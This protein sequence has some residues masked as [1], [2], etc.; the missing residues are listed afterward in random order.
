MGP[1]LP[2]A[3]PVAAPPLLP[4]L[5]LAPPLPPPPL[6]PEPP[7]AGAPELPLPVGVPIPPEPAGGV[8]PALPPADGVPPLP[9]PVADVPPV[10]GPPSGDPPRDGAGIDEH[11]RNQQAA[12][13]QHQKVNRRERISFGTSDVPYSTS[14]TPR[15]LLPPICRVSTERHARASS[16][17]A[18]SPAATSSSALL[19]TSS[20]PRRRGHFQ[21]VTS[22]LAPHILGV[23]RRRDTCVTGDGGALGSRRA[24]GS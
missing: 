9:P 4:L 21:P 8:V 15:K 23:R 7:V 6:P 10:P 11:A 17:S 3:P 5:P 1:A 12:L 13:V 20:L 18:C 2:P 22:C 19:G 24:A 16:R 14:V